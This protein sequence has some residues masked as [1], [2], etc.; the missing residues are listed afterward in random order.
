MRASSKYVAIY[1]SHRLVLYTARYICVYSQW[2]VRVGSVAPM[3]A[4][5]VCVCV[6]YT[7]M[8]EERRR[9]HSERVRSFLRMGAKVVTRHCWYGND[10][11]P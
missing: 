1:A 6:C 11:P 10:R 2:Q 7:C 3:R 8:G 9:V 5:C 4:V